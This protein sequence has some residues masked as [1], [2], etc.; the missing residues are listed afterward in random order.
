MK[1]LLVIMFCL[2]CSI[3]YCLSPGEHL[4]CGDAGIDLAPGEQAVIFGEVNVGSSAEKP[5]FQ[6]SSPEEEIYLSIGPSGAEY[7]VPVRVNGKELATKELVLGLW[8]QRR[9]VEITLDWSWTLPP[10]LAFL[11]IRFLAWIRATYLLGA[12]VAKRRSR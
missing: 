9:G 10:T 7:S 2:S 12:F 8:S 4:F 1:K 5:L 6:L 11:L 3:G